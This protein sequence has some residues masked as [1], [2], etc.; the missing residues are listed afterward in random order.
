[1]SWTDASVHFPALVLFRSS[2]SS[3]HDATGHLRV[4][5]TEVSVR[6]WSIEPMGELFV[7][8]EYWRLELLL[9]ADDVVRYVVAIRPYDR[10]ADRHRYR[11]RGETEVVHHHLVSVRGLH[12]GLERHVGDRERMVDAVQRDPG[13]AKDLSQP[14]VGDFQRPG[15]RSRARRRLRKR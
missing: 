12:F 7:G 5:R 9:N 3:D 8:V 11:G 4:D 1:I 13:K 14:V 6:P 10:R 2:M 15:G